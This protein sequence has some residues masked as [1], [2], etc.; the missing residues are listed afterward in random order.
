MLWRSATCA[1]RG[2]IPPRKKPLPRESGRS[3]LPT[4]FRLAWKPALP[5]QFSSAIWRTRMILFPEKHTP[6]THSASWSGTEPKVYYKSGEAW[7]RALKGSVSE[8]E[9]KRG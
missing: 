6:P 4:M 5:R 2:C 7:V 8:V 3:I 1:T 9:V